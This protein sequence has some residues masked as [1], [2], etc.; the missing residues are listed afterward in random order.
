MPVKDSNTSAIPPGSAFFV[1]GGSGFVGRQL[2]KDLIAQGYTV[3]ALARSGSAAATVRALGAEPVAGDLSDIASMEAG[4]KECIAAIHC[5]AHVALWGPWED[6]ARDT[7]A[8]T[9]N[10][11]TAARRAGVKRFVHVSTEAVLADGHAIINADEL[12]PLPARPNGPYPK[13]KGEAERRVLSAN[14]SQMAT[15]VVRPR[16][17]WGKGDTTLLPQLV[18]AM[19]SGQWMWFGGGRHRMST[20]HVRNVSHGTLL[21][22]QAGRGGEIYFLTDGEPVV[23]RDFVSRM[24][25]TRNV[26]APDRTAPMWVADLSAAMS[27][28]AWRI[29]RLSGSPPLTRT[30][31]NLM[32]REVTVNDR[33]ARA[34]IGYMPV[35]S[36]DA[37]LA[38]LQ[39]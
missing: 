24:V 8:G 14:G 13:S 23:F 31:V 18:Q 35:V 10:V 27:E 15:V 17:V 36:I 7:I 30:A 29:F 21:A 39:E 20:C 22:A 19:K 25:K 1:T 11:L 32:F 9:D 4:M 3:R 2:I 33:K 38:E 34:D 37:G 5:A 28:I 16:F 12:R 26:T 6:F